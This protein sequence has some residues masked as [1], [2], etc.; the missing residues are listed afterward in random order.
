MCWCTVKK[1]LTHPPP[2]SSY[3]VWERCKLL[4]WIMEEPGR[5]TVFSA[6]WAENASSENKFTYYSMQIFHL[7]VIKTPKIFSYQ[8]L[9]RRKPPNTSLKNDWMLPIYCD[10]GLFSVAAK[11]WKYLQ[12]VSKSVSVKLYVGSLTERSNRSVTEKA[13]EEGASCKFIL[14]SWHDLANRCNLCVTNSV[15]TCKAEI[16]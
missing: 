10:A 5:K 14:S 7:W 1:L 12:R 4:Q 3:E 15:R 16:K 9:G 8:K 13:T 6:F 11:Y 2:Q